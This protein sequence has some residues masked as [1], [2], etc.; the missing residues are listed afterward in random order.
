[1]AEEQSRKIYLIGLTSGSSRVEQEVFAG[2][3]ELEIRRIS[4]VPY[5]KGR[6]AKRL[7]W[8][9]R[10]NLRLIREVMR[11]PASRG[12]E[13]LFTGAPPFMLFF[14]VPLKVLR[15]VRLIY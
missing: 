15:K 9:I 1:M 5:E 11:N 14:A 12:A 4:A 10:T 3:G 6:I 2:G 8:T 7:F 13:V